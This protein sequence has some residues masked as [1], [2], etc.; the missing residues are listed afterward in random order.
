MAITLNARQILALLAV[1][2]LLSAAVGFF[3]ARAAQPSTAAAGAGA[4]AG[5]SSKQLNAIVN[6]LRELNTATGSI[7]ESLTVRGMLYEICK[8]INNSFSCS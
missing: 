3:A 1:I 2:V 7:T 4:S 6:E 8:R 5:G